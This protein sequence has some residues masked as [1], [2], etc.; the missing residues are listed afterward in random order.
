M[1]IIQ[2]LQEPPAAASREEQAMSQ[3]QS[4]VPAAASTPAQA[5]EQAPAPQAASSRRLEELAEQILAELRRQRE[6]PPGDF[7]LSK[8]LAGVVQVL[9][10][11][12]MFYAY[13]RPDAASAQGWL[14]WAIVLQ[15]LVIALLI[16]GQQR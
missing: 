4:L 12:V 2:Q 9:V 13:L 16:M 14:L 8:L 6:Q 11:A 3:R 7:S 1:S 15:I 10:L 5:A